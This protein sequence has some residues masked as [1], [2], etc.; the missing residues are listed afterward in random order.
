[1]S[2]HGL[3]HGG[4]VFI[5][6]G[7]SV[8]GVTEVVLHSVIDFLKCENKTNPHTDQFLHILCKIFYVI[9]IFNG[10]F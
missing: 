8:L 9:L 6:T 1:L 10:V 7:S 2:A 3:I 5:V 4:V